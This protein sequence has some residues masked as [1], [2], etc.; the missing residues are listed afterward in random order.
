MNDYYYN[1]FTQM[2]ED[3]N[4]YFETEMLYLNCYSVASLSP[5]IPPNG[6]FFAS[7]KRPAIPL[8]LMRDEDVF[9][10]KMTDDWIGMSSQ[11]HAVYQRWCKDGK[12]L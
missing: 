6:Y 11:I 9:Y 5:E 8:H 7:A 10:C 2:K 4:I 3:G 12:N 1:I